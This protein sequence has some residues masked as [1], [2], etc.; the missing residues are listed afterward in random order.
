MKQL[1]K[2]TL[3]AAAITATCGTAVAGTVNVVKQVHSKEGLNGVTATQTSNA[4]SYTLAAAYRE[5][6]KVT[7][8]FTP[9]ALVAASFDTVVNLLPVNSDDSTKAIAG[10]T[11]GLL[12]NTD[13]AV[14]YR[15]TKLTL[16]TNV[17]GPI[18]EWQNGS[19]LGAEFVLPTIGYKAASV[20]AGA[21][22][23]SVSSQTTAG[24]VLDN[25]GTR[26][27]TIAEAKTQYGSASMTTVFDNVI[28]VS[29]SRKAFVNA[30][31]DWAAYAVTNP[32]TTGWLNMASTNTTSVEFIGEQDKMKGIKTA[33]FSSGGTRT[34]TEA[35]S[36]LAIS[37][38]GMSTNDVITFTPTT[39]ANAV[40]LETQRFAANVTYNYVSAGSV[41]GTAPV[42]S[43]MKA[44]EWTLN[45]ATVNVPYLPYG[46]SASRIL[47]ISNAGSQAGDIIATAFDDKGNVYNLGKI[48]VANG[49]TV[50]KIAR[51]VDDALETKGFK[52]TKVSLTLT[53][54][55]PE[56]DI[57]V[58][59][60]YNIGNADRGFVNTD[61]YKGI[62]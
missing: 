53:V 28:D 24:D 54:N 41:A 44:G 59:A 13:D 61:Q 2:T 18:V 56:D 33:N 52:G 20:L 39:G 14:T 10:L 31:Y 34:F 5:G 47:Y 37:Y 6:D 55:A 30:S 8:T 11:L 49:N 45:G 3:L 4:I 25:A 32:T 62:K 12:N 35:T 22:T 42:G 40:I 60:S 57:T 50:A 38:T 36:T 15:V 17:T 51:E 23:V 43:A 48:G 9:G 16:P 29:Q 19:T 1:F 27:G 21:V 58:Y 26:T 46:P 7:F